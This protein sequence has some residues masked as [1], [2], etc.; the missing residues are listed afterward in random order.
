MIPIVCAR[1]RRDVRVRAHRRARAR[2]QAR[3]ELNHLAHRHV[4]VGIRAVVAMAGKAALP[5]GRE[6]PQ[7]IPALAPPGVRHLSAFED[8]VIDR[9]VGEKPARREAGVTGPDD[10]RGDASIVKR[11]RR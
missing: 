5:V 8:D 2:W 6:E 3:D 4:A 11:L 1:E 9:P 7:R 10:D